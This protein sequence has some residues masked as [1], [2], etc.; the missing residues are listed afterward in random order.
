MQHNSMAGDVVILVA[1]QFANC[2]LLSLKAKH[3]SKYFVFVAVDGHKTVCQLLPQNFFYQQVRQLQVAA[4]VA[5]VEHMP[6]LH[7]HH[8]HN[9]RRFTF[10]VVPIQVEVQEYYRRKKA[11]YASCHSQC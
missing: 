9:N 5:N 2:V 11:V 6:I 8:I 1:I 4:T 7:M 10:F 3:C